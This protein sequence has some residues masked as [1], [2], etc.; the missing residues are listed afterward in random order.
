MIHVALDAATLKALHRLEA[1]LVGPKRG[2]TSAV[3]R[4]AIHDAVIG[5]KR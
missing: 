4:R 1:V 5:R 2:R 3:V